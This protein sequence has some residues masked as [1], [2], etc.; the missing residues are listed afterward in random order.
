MCFFAHSYFTAFHSHVIGLV[1]TITSIRSPLLYYT[2][3]ELFAFVVVAR[4][5]NSL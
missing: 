5:K 4:T 1:L 2:A 3:I